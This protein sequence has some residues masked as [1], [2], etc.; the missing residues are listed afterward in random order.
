MEDYPRQFKENGDLR[1]EWMN[2]VTN[3]DFKREFI[4]RQIRVKSIF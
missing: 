4:G 2:K 3:E 1:R